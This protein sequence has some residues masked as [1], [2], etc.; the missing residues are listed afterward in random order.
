[1][2]I[3]QQNNNHQALATFSVALL[4]CTMITAQQQGP[5]LPVAVM[6]ADY[7]FMNSR[8]SFP[9]VRYQQYRWLSE[10]DRQK[11]S[12]AGYTPE[13]WD[14]PMSAVVESIPFSDLGILQ[15]KI[16][17]LGLSQEQWDCYINNYSGYKWDQLSNQLQ[18]HALAL[19]WTPSTWENSKSSNSKP[20]VF[21]NFWDELSDPQKKTAGEFCYFEN[22]WNEENLRYWTT[23]PPSEHTSA[24]TKSPT[25]A[26]GKTMAPTIAPLKASATTTPSLSIFLEVVLIVGM[27]F[28]FLVV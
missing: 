14:Q 19:G 6:P 22:T 16:T 2:V 26:P 18:I 5:P 21:R 1:M 28:A 3:N 10:E 15:S 23:A 8:I 4:A 7:S 24:P 9:E 13:E 11:V 20:A 27:G 25:T 17:A 12:E